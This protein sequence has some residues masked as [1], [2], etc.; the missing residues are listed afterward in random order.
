VFGG[1]IA[2]VLVGVLSDVLQ[3]AGLSPGDALRFSM[4]AFQ[5]VVMSAGTWLIVRASRTAQRDVEATLA[6]FLAE[7]TR[8]PRSHAATSGGQ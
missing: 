6:T 4:L 3:N 7:R 1:S 2:P 5:A 8:E